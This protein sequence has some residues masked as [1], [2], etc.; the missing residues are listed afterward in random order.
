MEKEFTNQNTAIICYKDNLKLDCQ[1][2]LAFLYRLSE[3]L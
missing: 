2:V 1:K 3:L